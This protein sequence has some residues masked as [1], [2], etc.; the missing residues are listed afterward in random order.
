MGWHHVRSIK[1]AFNQAQLWRSRLFIRSLAICWLTLGL[2]ACS[3][4]GLPSHQVIEQALSIHVEQI[5]TELSRQLRITEAPTDF[6][7]EHVVVSNQQ[8]FKIAE[9]PGYR[10]QGVYDYT[11]KAPNRELSRRNNPFEIYLQRQSES[12]TWRWARLQLDEA[13]ESTWVTRRLPFLGE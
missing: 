6:A 7:I 8:P 5:Q 3:V 10:V 4:G 11:L 9:L 13:G 12:K 2:T 1:F